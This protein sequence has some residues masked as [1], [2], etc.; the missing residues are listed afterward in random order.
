MNIKLLDSWI[1]EFVQT[2]ATVKEFADAMSQSSV[3]IERI[4][5]YG[6]DFLYDIF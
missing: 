6:N 1:R 5:K 4:E 2:K 3:S